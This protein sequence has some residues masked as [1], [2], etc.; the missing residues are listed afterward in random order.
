[1]ENDVRDVRLMKLGG[2]VVGLGNVAYIDFEE[3]E[4]GAA[5]ALLTLSSGLELEYLDDLAA[6]LAGFVRRQVSDWLL[7][8]VGAPGEVEEADQA[9]TYWNRPTRALRLFVEATRADFQTR[10]LNVAH[11]VAIAMAEDLSEAT[12]RM[13]RGQE[14]PLDGQE[15]KVLARWLGRRGDFLS[16]EGEE[17]GTLSLP[18]RNVGYVRYSLE[19]DQAAVALADG[20][21]HEY[22][23]APAAAICRYVDR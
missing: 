12:I 4:E 3:G 9:V 6:D 2:Y 7:I 21:V 15:A 16:V 11:V 8:R 20:E 22:E 18:L 1:M 14:I 23:G 17:G 5:R 10:A 13:T 19:H